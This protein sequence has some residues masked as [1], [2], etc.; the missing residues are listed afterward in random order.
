MR[1]SVAQYSKKLSGSVALMLAVLFSAAPVAAQGEFFVIP[2]VSMTFRGDWDVNTAYNAKDVVFHNGS[3]WFS[4][5][6]L[7]TGHEP[8]DSSP[9]W[10]MLVKKGDAGPMGPQGPAGISGFERPIASQW[11]DIEPGSALSVTAECSS[12]KVA[13]GGGGAAY[14]APSTPIPISASAPF[15]QATWTV[16][17]VNASGATVNMNVTAVAICGNY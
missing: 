2:V 10:T 6:G 1:Q 5:A 11:A 7:N 14:M 12:G 4:L 17:A 13:I 15:D 16:T 3:S 9:Q 8:N